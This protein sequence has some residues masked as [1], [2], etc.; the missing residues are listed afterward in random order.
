MSQYTRILKT[1][2]WVSSVHQLVLASCRVRGVKWTVRCCNIRVSI[3]PLRGKPW[4]DLPPQ[5][6]YPAKSE[7]RNPVKRNSESIVAGCRKV[8]LWDT[9]GAPACQSTKPGYTKKRVTTTTPNKKRVP[10]GNSDI[11]SIW[12]KWLPK[13]KLRSLEPY[14]NHQIRA[15][16]HSKEL[17]AHTKCTKR[18]HRNGFAEWIS[19]NIPGLII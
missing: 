17:V 1:N 10:S 5:P 19:F 13:C 9:E 11:L 16:P 8:S 15:W 18:R 3:P 4:R 14:F 2:I 12:E 7:T 6:F